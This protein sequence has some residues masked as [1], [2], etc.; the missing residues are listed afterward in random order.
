[1]TFPC[2]ILVLR[3][4]HLSS[5]SDNEPLSSVTFP[6]VL[7][8]ALWYGIVYGIFGLGGSVKSSSRSSSGPLESESLSSSLSDGLSTGASCVFHSLRAD[9]RCCLQA[10]NRCYYYTLLHIRMLETKSLLDLL[11]RRLS[12]STYI[13]VHFSVV[14]PPSIKR[15][16]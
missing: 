10:F 16:V 6:R 5:K 11:N 1:M 4:E 13:D 3:C 14:G 12:G 15:Q 2:R 7:S 8:T 9:E